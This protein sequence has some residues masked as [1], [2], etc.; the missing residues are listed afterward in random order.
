MEEDL[1]RRILARFAEMGTSFPVQDL[2]EPT[3]RSPARLDLA[4]AVVR[5]LRVSSD[6]RGRFNVTRF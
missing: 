2:A 3:R 4:L 5:L 1:Q 6:P